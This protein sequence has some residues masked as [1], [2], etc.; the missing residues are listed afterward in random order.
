[1]TPQELSK[2]HKQAFPNARYWTEEEF[3]VLLAKPATL[4]VSSDHGFALGQ[5]IAPE[6]DL[7]MIAIEP[8]HQGNG[9]GSDLMNKFEQAA[10]ERGAIKILLEV[11][12]SDHTVLKFYERFSFE[13]IRRLPAY[14]SKK[15][16]TKTDAILMQKLL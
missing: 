1:M 9:L 14:Y 11:D 3:E 7:Q 12:A 16:G 5:V 4:F 10:H 6:C 15:D 2:L 13:A 8:A